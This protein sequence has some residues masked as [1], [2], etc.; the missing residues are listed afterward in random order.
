MQRS[1]ERCLEGVSW[2]SCNRRRGARAGTKKGGGPAGPPPLAGGFDSLDLEGLVLPEPLEV[3]LL[4]DQ[5]PPVAELLAH[6]VG[7]VLE[8]AGHLHQVAFPR[9][10]GVLNG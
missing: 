5:V 2:V 10:A 6:L 7:V 9:P 8:V 1:W 4:D 3:E